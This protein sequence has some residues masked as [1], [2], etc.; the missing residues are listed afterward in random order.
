M[1]QAHALRARSRNTRF[2]ANQADGSGFAADCGGDHPLRQP[3]QIESTNFLTI[4]DTMQTP[5]SRR[6]V[7]FKVLEPIVVLDAVLVMNMLCA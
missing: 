5:V 2:L 4:D 7:D 6:S 3:L 1:V